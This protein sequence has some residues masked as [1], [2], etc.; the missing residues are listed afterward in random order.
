MTD[1]ERITFLEARIA[2]LEA[3]LAAVEARGSLWAQ[4]QPSWPTFPNV[5]C[6]TPTSGKPDMPGT[7]VF[8][9]AGESFTTK[10]PETS[11]QRSSVPYAGNWGS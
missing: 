2:Q 3:R 7:T 8:C 1:Q 6:S 10:E 11:L 4:S 5:W 9:G